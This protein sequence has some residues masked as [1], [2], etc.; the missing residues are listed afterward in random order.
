MDFKTAKDRISII[1]V[2]LELGYK[3]DKSKGSRQPSFVLLNSNNDVLDR[4]YIK[5]PFSNS[6]QGF[7]RRNLSSSSVE[8]KGDLITFVK[9]NLSKFNEYNS[10]EHELTII[11]KILSRFSNM[12]LSSLSE[13]NTLKKQNFSN[14]EF[15]LN[16]YDISKD[17]FLAYPFFNKRNISK[18]TVDDFKDFIFTIKDKESR[19]NY[20]NL[21]FPM[22]DVGTKKIE[23]F[24]IRGLEGFK[25]KAKGSKYN[26]AWIADLSKNNNEVNFIFWAESAYDLL[27]LY[28]INKN[29]IHLNNSVFVS[30]GG[31]FSDKL[32]NNISSHYKG[33]LNIL[34]FDNDIVGVLYSIRALCLLADKKL[35]IK[36]DSSTVY[37]KTLT[38]SFEIEQNKLTLDEFQK[39]SG[40]KNNGLLEMFTAPRK[41]KDWNQLLLENIPTELRINKYDSNLYKK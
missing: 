30:T 13:F 17:I 14:E 29:R 25:A 7:W 22:Y 21:G 34:S 6:T 8:M 39:R 38:V 37:F 26:S 10:N 12:S 35:E 41:F 40:I 23:G 27:S 9:E 5:N 36:V 11:N 18:E 4:I 19:Y 31:N 2:A 16:R 28:Q 20:R 1:Q 15:D 24:E 33:A 32:F 3:H